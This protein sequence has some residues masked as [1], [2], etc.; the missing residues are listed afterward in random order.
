MKS[1]QRL[2]HV[3]MVVHMAVPVRKVTT[4]TAIPAKIA[5]TQKLLPAVTPILTLT[6]AVLR[7][8]VLPIRT[9]V[10]AP[11]VSMSVMQVRLTTA[12]PVIRLW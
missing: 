12:L 2:F 1:M 5:V 10:H 4:L 8:M 3:L 11:S 6:T 9:K 7:I